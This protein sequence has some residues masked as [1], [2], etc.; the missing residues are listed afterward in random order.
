MSYQ[1]VTV[2]IYFRFTGG[3]PTKYVYNVAPQPWDI[4]KLAVRR[5]KVMYDVDTNLPLSVIDSGPTGE[6]GETMKKK[7]LRALLNQDDI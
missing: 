4:A 2:K 3:Y 5:S 1:I 7:V 6:K